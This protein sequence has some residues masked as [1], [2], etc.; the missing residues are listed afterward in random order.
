MQ[1]DIYFLAFDV[2]VIK[3]TSAFKR[4][5]DKNSTNSAG[6]YIEIANIGETGIRKAPIK[7][8]TLLLTTFPIKELK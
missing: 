5:F 2:E 7:S 6:N 3:Y 4:E 1:I 8:I